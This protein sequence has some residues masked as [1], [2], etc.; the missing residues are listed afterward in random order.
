MLNN[1][2]SKDN[3]LPCLRSTKS[4]D[5]NFNSSKWTKVSRHQE[6]FKKSSCN[7][8]FTSPSLHCLTCSISF[9]KKDPFHSWKSKGSKRAK[10]SVFLRMRLSL[11]NWDYATPFKRQLTSVRTSS[12]IWARKRTVSNL[13]STSSTNAITKL[14]W[15]WSWRLWHKLRANT[16]KSGS[17]W[18]K[19]LIKLQVFC[20]LTSRPGQ[21]E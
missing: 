3:S 8:N 16:L 13:L 21:D 9:I 14:T 5:Q 12:Q 10:W 11:P 17:T 4:L 6:A 15:T 1:K 18:I 7:A 2:A 20:L 19:R